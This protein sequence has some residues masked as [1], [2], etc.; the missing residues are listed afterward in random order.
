MSL[1]LLSRLKKYIHDE[2]NSDLDS[3]YAEC[4]NAG[5]TAVVNGM[6]IWVFKKIEN[7]RFHNN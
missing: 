2:E 1:D 5:L 6:D 4:E 7:D 3:I